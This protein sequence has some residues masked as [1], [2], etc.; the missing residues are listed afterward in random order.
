MWISKERQQE[1][2]G[3]YIQFHG[4]NSLQ[5]FLKLTPFYFL[6]NLNN[7]VI[8][9]TKCSPLIFL[10]AAHAS[11]M[12]DCLFSPIILPMPQGS[13]KTLTFAGNDLRL[14]PSCN[15]CQRRLLTELHHTEV[16]FIPQTLPY[17][18]RTIEGLSFL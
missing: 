14:S 2:F 5:I 9:D 10:Y 15:S 13:S 1:T 11:N 6:D 3:F 16:W 12:M 7:W 8:W 18:T 17:S 4:N